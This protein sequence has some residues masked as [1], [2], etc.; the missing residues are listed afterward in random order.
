VQSEHFN[1]GKSPKWRKLRSNYRKLKRKSVRAYFSKFFTQVKATEKHKFYMKVK[2]IGGLQPAGGGE[3]KIECLEGKSDYECAEEVARAF[4]SVSN[5][6]LPVGLN[7]LPAF[8][9]CLPPPQ[10]TQLQ[11]YNRILKL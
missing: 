10:V 3:L 11:V 9:P 4:A 2:E 7:Q 1:K 5:E 8:L 6:Y